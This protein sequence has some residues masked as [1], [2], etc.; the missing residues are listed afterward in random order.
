[1]SYRT[2]VNDF[3]VFGNNDG[4]NKW[5]VGK[6]EYLDTIKSTTRNKFSNGKEIIEDNIIGEPIRMSNDYGRLVDSL[7]FYPWET[8]CK[9]LVFEPRRY[10][11]KLF[12]QAA[13]MSTIPVK[14]SDGSPLTWMDLT[15]R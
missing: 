12:P 6:G 15:R 4:Y 11:V 10:M 1:M 8:F 5:I 3:Q 14:S 13:Q 2:Y 7:A 9:D